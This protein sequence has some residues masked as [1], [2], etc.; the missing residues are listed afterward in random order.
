V[1][2]NLYITD[3]KG[4]QSFGERQE[5]ASAAVRLAKADYFPDVSAIAW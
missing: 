1:E 2:S 3:F 5:K 4:G